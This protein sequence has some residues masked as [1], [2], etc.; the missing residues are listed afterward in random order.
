MQTLAVT[1][2]SNINRETIEIGASIDVHIRQRANGSEEGNR[3]AVDVVAARTGV[4][5]SNRSTRNESLHPHYSFTYTSRFYTYYSPLPREATPDF[6]RKITVK[7][8]SASLIKE[9]G[10][11]KCLVV[12]RSGTASNLVTFW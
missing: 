11:Y 4:V 2:L 12:V 1:I 5:F 6:I 3:G 7:T 9:W 8:S 10:S